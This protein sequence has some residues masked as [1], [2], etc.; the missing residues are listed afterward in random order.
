ML[1]RCNLQQGDGVTPL[2]REQMEHFRGV[3]ASL[4]LSDA[5]KDEMIR[6]VDSIAISFIDQAFGIDSIQLSLSARANFRFLGVG[7]YAKLKPRNRR[8]KSGVSLADSSNNS[9]P[10]SS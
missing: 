5:R 1:R 4:D 6:M 9:T 8:V 3:I 7:E 10:E 2:T